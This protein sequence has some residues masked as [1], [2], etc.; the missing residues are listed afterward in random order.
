MKES[1]SSMPTSCHLIPNL[2]R[3][4]GHYIFLTRKDNSLINL[5]NVNTVINKSE[6]EV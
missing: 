1:I 4:E 6:W 3:T 5:I 2:T